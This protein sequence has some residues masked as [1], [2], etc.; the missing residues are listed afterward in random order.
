MIIPRSLKPLAYL[1]R[2][3]GS[4]DASHPASLSG[5]P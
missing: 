3:A 2:A 4:D 5:N 1:L